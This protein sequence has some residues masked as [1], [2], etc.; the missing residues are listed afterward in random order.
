M[1]LSHILIWLW[2]SQS[3]IRRLLICLSIIYRWLLILHNIH[4]FSLIFDR[5]WLSKLRFILMN[6]LSSR[7]SI[8]RFH[9]LPIITHTHFILFFLWWIHIKC[10]FATASFKLRPWCVLFL[11]ISHFQWR[12]MTMNVREA[13]IILL[14]LVKIAIEACKK[15]STWF[16]LSWEWRNGTVSLVVHY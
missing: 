16:I 7:L 13:V 11:R 4:S 5:N 1:S 3:N 8:N 14:S 10:I 12:F 9:F 15:R 2:I 6:A